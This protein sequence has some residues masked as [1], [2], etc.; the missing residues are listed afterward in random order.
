MTARKSTRRQFLKGAAATT[1]GALALPLF[2]PATALGRDDKK[3]AAS[4]RLVIGVIGAE[5]RALCKAVADMKV[6]LQ[7]GSMERS[8]DNIRR[9]AQLVKEGRIGKLHTVRI[10]LPC[11]DAHHKAARALKDVPPPEP[12]PE[13]F[14][15]DTWL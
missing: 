10:S 3:A 9:V 13:G 12:V 8:G 1:A 15:Y 11:T 14:D 5:G 7:C 6:V 2:V 4:D